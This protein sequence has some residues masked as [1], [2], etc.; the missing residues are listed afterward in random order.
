MR[1]GIQE[2]N[3]RKYIAT[4][5]ELGL[6]NERRRGDRCGQFCRPVARRQK[7]QCRYIAAYPGSPG[8]VWMFGEQD[9]VSSVQ[10]CTTYGKK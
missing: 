5:R 7:L 9:L 1:A 2:G 8:P 10:L 3:L 4:Q 6:P